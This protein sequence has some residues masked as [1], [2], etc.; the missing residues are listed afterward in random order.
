MFRYR[1]SFMC[2]F[3]PNLGAVLPQRSE[4]GG[5]GSPLGAEVLSPLRRTEPWS[6]RGLLAALRAGWKGPT[7]TRG[8]ASDDAPWRWT[9]RSPSPGCQSGFAPGC[10]AHLPSWCSKTR[11]AS[12]PGLHL[13]GVHTEH[14]DICKSWKERQVQA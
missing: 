5:V 11:Q 2:N 6:S 14:A 13:R 4:A 12:V 1:V 8:D 3:A 7:A 10:R 9:A